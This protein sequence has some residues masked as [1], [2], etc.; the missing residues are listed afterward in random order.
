MPYLN[1]P[2]LTKLANQ[3][4]TQCS[5]VN[6]PTNLIR[7]APRSTSQHAPT[8][9]LHYPPSP[10]VK[11]TVY[12]HLP[13]NLLHTAFRPP[14]PPMQGRNR[15]SKSPRIGG[16]EGA[17]SPQTQTRN[18]TTLINAVSTALINAVSRYC[19][20]YVTTEVLHP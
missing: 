14:S 5:S 1:F 15:N 8:H 11:A 4:C 18:F 2:S 7:V 6:E 17:R 10:L 16:C 20:K 13:I 19:I 3:T 9:V 12:T